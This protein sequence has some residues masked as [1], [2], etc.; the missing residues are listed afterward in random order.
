MTI[1]E[2][3]EKWTHREIPFYSCKLRDTMTAEMKADLEEMLDMACEAGRA[4]EKA[5]AK[6]FH[7]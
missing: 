3:L 7:P 2:F 5:C 4:M 6:D 1:D